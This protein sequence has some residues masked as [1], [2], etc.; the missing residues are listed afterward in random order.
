MKEITKKHYIIGTLIISLALIA[1]PFSLLFYQMKVAPKLA[2]MIL[3]KQQDGSP[4]VEGKNISTE[5]LKVRGN[6]DAEIMLVEFSDYECPFCQRFHE[7]PKSI[8]AN[9]NG[10]VAW[11]WRHFPLNQIHPNAKPASIAAECVNKIA[12][13]DAFWQFTD[14]LVANQR[15]LN[16]NFYKTESAKLGANATAFDA[17]TKDPAIAAIVDADQA[18]GESLGVNGTPNT[19]VVEN[20]N[21]KLTILESIN[22]ALPQDTVEKIVAK[23]VK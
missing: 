23:Y 17:C 21:G 18:E 15:N 9:S 2:P 19:L 20:K 5:N 22:G 4:V 14:I 8:V 3:G 12:G 10:K 13:T 16:S 11:A 6:K 1:Q 7:A